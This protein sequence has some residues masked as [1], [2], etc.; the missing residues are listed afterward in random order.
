MELSRLGRE[1]NLISRNYQTTE[2]DCKRLKV[3]YENAQLTIKQ[4]ST[5]IEH[6]EKDKTLIE[7]EYKDFRTDSTRTDREFKKAKDVSIDSHL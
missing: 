5:E 1:K 3:D 2:E 6:L 4:Q 7:N